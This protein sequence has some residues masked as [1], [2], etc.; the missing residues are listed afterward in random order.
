M[1]TTDLGNDWF[2]N[3]HDDGSMTLRN[4][5]QGQ[6]IDL[7]SDSVKRL[8]SILADA[9]LLAIAKNHEKAALYYAD[10]AVREGYGGLG[11]RLTAAATR[12][13]IDRCSAE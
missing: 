11:F 5:E 1:K 6:R 3:E 4:C 13:V 8:R 9:E 2:A 12:A 7:P 10:K